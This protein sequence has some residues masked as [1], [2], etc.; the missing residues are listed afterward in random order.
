MIHKSKIFSYENSQA[1]HIPVELAF[2]RS[3]IEVEMERSGDEI[4]VRPV[5]RLAT[6]VLEKLTGFGQ[7][8]T[9]EGRGD[10]GQADRE[11]L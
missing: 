1:V 4:R 11:A 9:A 10:E 6:G 7:D 3:D 2:E 8:F 5:G